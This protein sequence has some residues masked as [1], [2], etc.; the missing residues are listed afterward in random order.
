MKRALI[1][2]SE[3][4]IGFNLSRLLMDQNI[5]IIGYD[6]ENGLDLLDKETLGRYMR[7]ADMCFHLGAYGNVPECERTPYKAIEGNIISTMNVLSL[8]HD[9]GVKVVFSSSFAVLHPENR[10]SVYG[11]TKALDEKLVAYYDGIICRISNVF[12]GAGY[13][14][15]KDSVI[16]RLINGT[17]EDRGHGDEKRDF[18]HVEDVCKKLLWASDQPPYNQNHIIHEIK[19]GY[20]ISINELIALSKKPDFP[21]N[22]RNPLI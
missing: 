13:T 12:G 1:T 20:E 14:M 8:A 11:L 17:F 15:K 10:Q 3:G 22:I 4:Y 5:R 9:Y 6:I 7:R 21:N 16:A 18:I 2:G 19:S